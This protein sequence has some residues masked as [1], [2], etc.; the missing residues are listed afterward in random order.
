MFK[1]VKWAYELGVKTEHDRLYNRLMRVP[2]P[3]LEDFDD[4]MMGLDPH[5]PEDIREEKRKEKYHY[6]LQNWF[7]F[8]E[9]VGH[10]FHPDEEQTLVMQPRSDDE[11][12]KTVRGER[13]W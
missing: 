7:S 1:L 13:R 4:R 2:K 9:W 10:I 11:F 5:M 6:A 8:R 12:M 3:A